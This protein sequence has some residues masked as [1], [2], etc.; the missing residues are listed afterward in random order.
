M[1]TTLILCEAWDAT[2]NQW[3][4]KKVE[5]IF[6]DPE[7]PVP[8]DN[9]EVAVETRNGSLV[10]P[11]WEFSSEVWVYTRKPVSEVTYDRDSQEI[12]NP[13]EIVKE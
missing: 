8:S 12:V 13:P 2:Q 3:T 6:E 5:F 1:P 11:D 9:V 7:Y 10:P 4:L